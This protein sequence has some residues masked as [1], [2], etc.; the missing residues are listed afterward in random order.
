MQWEY[1]NN[2]VK[3]KYKPPIHGPSAMKSYMKSEKLNS[4]MKVF[5][6]EKR[7]KLLEK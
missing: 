6:E 3:P 2:T 1:Y 7:Q 5:Y 4:P